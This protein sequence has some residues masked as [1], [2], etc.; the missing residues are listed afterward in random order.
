ML[1]LIAGALIVFY[2][3][4]DTLLPDKI[5][6]VHPKRGKS[7]E[8]VYATGIVEP[9][10]SAQI[11]PNLSAPI[12]SILA[13]EGQQVKKG[14]VLAQLDDTDAQ[15]SLAEWDAKR[16][17]SAAE[18]KRY[19]TLYEKGFVSKQ[20]MDKINSELAQIDANIKSALQLIEDHKIIS[21]MDGAVIRRDGEVGELADKGK[22]LYSVGQGKPYRVTADVDEEDIPK[23]ALSQRALIKADAFPGKILEGTVNEITPKGDPIAKTYRVRLLLP[24]DSPLMVGMTV[25]VNIITNIEENALLVPK[26]AVKEGQ[27]QLLR[28]GK[29]AYQKVEAGAGG[30]NSIEIKSGVA[31]NDSVVFNYTA[32]LKEGKRFREKQ[33]DFAP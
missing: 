26:T 23:V 2:I 12:E 5:E 21:P 19:A 27:V 9:V 11:S 10:L 4:L 24:E 7:I 31:E 30:G 29:I 28:D 6:T 17:F 1:A 14:D 20:T 22:V 8:A 16:V 3:A 13:V 32:T 33:I 15:A 18:K 25:E